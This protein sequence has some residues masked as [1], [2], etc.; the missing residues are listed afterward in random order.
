[1]EN[2]NNPQKDIMEEKAFEN[3]ELL[4]PEAEEPVED[5]RKPK[6]P[7]K[8]NFSIN[9]YYLKKSSYSVA[10]TAIVV[11]A[12]I[13][14]NILVSALSDRFVL[15]Y[16][17]TVE[18]ENSISEDN[19]KFLKKIEK[20]VTVTFCADEEEYSSNMGYY[21][22]SLYGV[23]DN[24]AV[25][26]YDQT[27]KLIKL[28]NSYNKKI[29]VNFV[30]TQ[31]TEFTAI[32]KEYSDETLSYGDIIVSAETNGNKRYKKVGYNDIYYTAEDETY[33]MYG[34]SIK[35]VTGNNLETAVTSAIAFVT[36]EK[37][38]NA[39]IITGHS[40]LDYSEK[41]K[42]LLEENNYKVSVINNPVI[43][44]ISPDVNVLVI[45]AATKDFLESEIE[46][47][48]EFLDNGSK[49]GKG[50]LVFADA[51]SPY[52]NN[53]YGFLEEW[54]I[55]VGDGILFETDENNYIPGD[56]TTMGSYNSGNDDG[57]SNMQICISAHNVP[58]NA[59]FEQQNFFEVKSLIETP[60]TVVA[61]PTGVSADWTPNDSYVK[62]AYPTVLESAK[63]SYNEDNEE[64]A[65]YVTVF[66]SVDFLDSEYNES[67]SVSNKDITLFSAN[68]GAGA[69]DTGISF[70]FKEI[71]NESFAD[72]VNE[73]TANIIR[74][75]FV[76]LLPIAVIIAGV[77]VYFRR[78]N[79]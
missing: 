29:K 53:L 30:D 41:Y 69:E 73:Q 38:K 7:I 56:P 9:K 1:M 36:D 17:M 70:I 34:Y 78:R 59:L 77:V 79:S 23:S 19:I 52:L 14:L 11:A 55:S 51:S 4:I 31:S 26:Y 64:I 32:S 57:I 3:G 6:K 75:I 24:A 40:S 13:V 39:A 58:L 37:E 2:N 67:S 12:V 18:K 61:A 63:S 5:T 71:T 16:D 20:D 25:K 42:A 44:E 15:E 62:K 21:A 48:S 47:I 33:A 49:L 8:F 74:L 28:Y 50:L 43:T 76:V 27:V 60:D 68:R 65:S 22:Y 45:P 35:T 54:G 66:S 10:I 72:S 46:V